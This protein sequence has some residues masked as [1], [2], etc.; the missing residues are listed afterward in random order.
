MM[1]NPASTINTDKRR[2]FVFLFCWMVSVFDLMAIALYVNSPAYQRMVDVHKA[3]GDPMPPMSGF[4]WCLIALFVALNP[5]V[6]ACGYFIGLVIERSSPAH[7]WPT[8]L[9]VLALLS[10]V[11][12][13]A[14]GGAIAAGLTRLFKTRRR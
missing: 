5:P 6:V 13:Y 10:G 4:L 11:W 2:R 7:L 14:V 8:L 1:G 9:V 3:I 12:W